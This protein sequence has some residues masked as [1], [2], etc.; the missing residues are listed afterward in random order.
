MF[1]YNTRHPKSY[2]IILFVELYYSKYLTIE[3]HTRDFK[4]NPK[5]KNVCYNGI[6]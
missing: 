4:K 6:L 3:I 1:W 2:S 5:S